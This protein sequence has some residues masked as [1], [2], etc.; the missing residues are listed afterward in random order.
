MSSSHQ[1]SHQARLEEAKDL[2]EQLSKTTQEALRLK[3]NYEAEL[4]KKDAEIKTLKGE[5][6][7]LQLENR[8][9]KEVIKEIA[10]V[11]NPKQ[12]EE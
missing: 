5:V 9:L 8:V 6:S 7:A 11:I 12:E 2:E 3:K 10:H 1:P 4:A